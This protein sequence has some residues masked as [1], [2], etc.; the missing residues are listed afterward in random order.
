MGNMPYYW[1]IR[2]P[3]G[4]TP[5][6]PNGPLPEARSQR[7]LPS[8][9]FWCRSVYKMA[10][11]A[12]LSKRWHIVLRC[13]IWGPLGLLILIRWNVE[14]RITTLEL[15]CNVKG[16]VARYVHERY[17]RPSASQLR[18]T[19]GCVVGHMCPFTAGCVVGHMCPSVLS[20]VQWRVFRLF[21]G[22]LK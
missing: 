10:A 7:P 6:S 16:L 8:L 14:D 20:R 22:S 1:S 18:P 4:V 19:S 21:L 5:H 12:D 17:E 13:M 9:R 15:C 2:K 3:A 11:Q